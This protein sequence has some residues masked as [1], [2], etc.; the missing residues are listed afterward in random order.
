MH[1]YDLQHL[2][3]TAAYS[4]CIY[5]QYWLLRKFAASKTDMDVEMQGCCCPGKTLSYATNLLVQLN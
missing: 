3:D 5:I 4:G 1:L 2:C